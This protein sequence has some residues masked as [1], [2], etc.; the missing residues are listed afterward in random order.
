MW[1]KKK[2]TSTIHTL[3]HTHLEP[4]GANKSGGKKE[5]TRVTWSTS[6]QQTNWALNLMKFLISGILLFTF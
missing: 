5:K 1:G 6:K 2:E 4:K 3:L